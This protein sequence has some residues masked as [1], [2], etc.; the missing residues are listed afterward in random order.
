MPSQ[1][2]LSVWILSVLKQLET[3]LKQIETPTHR[4]SRGVK[5]HIKLTNGDLA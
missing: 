5:A 3:C 4:V 2:A 1:L